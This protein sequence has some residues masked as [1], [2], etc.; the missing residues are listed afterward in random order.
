MEFNVQNNDPGIKEHIYIFSAK[1][2]INIRDKSCI[3]D[4]NHAFYIISAS[5]LVS[6]CRTV[7]SLC[8]VLKLTVGYMLISF[9]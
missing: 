2:N 9:K 7:P 1:Y 4:W 6:V 3:C 5:A 8:F